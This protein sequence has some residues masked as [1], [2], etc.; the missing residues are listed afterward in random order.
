ME[1]VY[2]DDFE[3][4]SEEIEYTGEEVCET[5][6]EISVRAMVYMKNSL[7]KIIRT[8]DQLH[9]IEFYEIYDRIIKYIQLNCEHNYVV[10]L[11]D[12]TPE[13]SQTICY[14]TICEQLKPDF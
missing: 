5:D 9:N 8:A 2:E 7:D 1:T 11:V 4:E 12:I 10:D 6:I 13:R 14:C 3:S